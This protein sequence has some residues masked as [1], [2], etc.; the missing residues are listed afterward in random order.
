MTGHEAPSFDESRDRPVIFVVDDD[1]VALAAIERD[2]SRRFGRDYHIVTAASPMVGVE[3]LE[4]LANEGTAVALIAA[5]LQMAEMTGPDFLDAGS[6]FHRDAKRILLVMASGPD[7]VAAPEGFPELQ[8][9]SP[10]AAPISRSSKGG[11]RR[12][13]GSIAKSRTR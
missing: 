13:S 2:L 4:G 9:A 3:L 6:S 7:I 1:P 11:S 12:K 8:N 5:S 10:L